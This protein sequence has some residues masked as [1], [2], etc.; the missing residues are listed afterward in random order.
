MTTPV[1]DKPQLKQI[2]EQLRDRRTELL[3]RVAAELTESG[4][5]DYIAI[6][7]TVHDAGDESVA[8]LLSDLAATQIQKEA[9]EIGDI[10]KTLTR[11]RQGSYGTCVDCSNQISGERLQIY[12][13]AKRCINCQ[14]SYED[15]RSEQDATPSL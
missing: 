5:K 12:P 8:D 4:D 6:A 15:N 9:E 7:G 1:L 10:E 3:Q 13:T 11:L 14:R 2:E